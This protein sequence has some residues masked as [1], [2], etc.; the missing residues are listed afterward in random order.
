MISGE[1]ILVTGPTGNLALPIVRRLA[2]DN[3]V[4]G[5]ARFTRPGDRD[6]LEA[7]GVVAVQRDL[8]TDRF[9]GLPRDFGYVLHA[10]GLIPTASERDWAYTFEANAQGTGRL[11]SHCR[12]AKGVVCVSTGGVYQ[13]TVGVRLTEGAPLGGNVPAYCLSKIAA[14]AVARFA[15]GEWRTPTLVL[16]MGAYFGPEA[17]GPA[18]ELLDRVARGKDIW[19]NPG[20]PNNFTLLWEEDAVEQGIRALT[21]GEV[22]AAV[23][24]WG[25]P[26]TVGLEEYCLAAGEL[27]GR[28]PTFVYT[29]KAYPGVYLDVSLAEGRLG[30][31]QVPWREGLRR[32]VAARFP[33][34]VA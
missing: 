5:L 11:M 12:S 18:Y 15:S 28:T 6:R 3:E 31:C 2:A 10:G 34:R 4:W 22:P 13:P 17:G 26:E 1:K 24:N 16:R 25:S 29:E 33:E 9:D 14:E 20:R 8:A 21:A 7:M 32:M 30:P 23:I 19:L 27:V